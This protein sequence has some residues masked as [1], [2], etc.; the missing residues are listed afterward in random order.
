MAQ[1]ITLSENTLLKLLLRRGSNEERKLVKPSKGELIYTVDSRRVFV[2]DGST[3]GGYVVGNKFYGSGTDV[4]NPTIPQNT[5]LTNGYAYYGDSYFNTVN[6]SYYVL[7]GTDVTN[8]SSWQMVGNITTGNNTTTIRNNDGT[9]SL[10][11]LSAG[12]F[13][14]KIFTGGLSS[15]GKYIS[16]GPTI[17]TNTILPLNG[18]TLT[19]SAYGNHYIQISDS[20]LKFAPD[21]VIPLELPKYAKF[22]TAEVNFTQG[23]DW[24]NKTGYVY[25][26]QDTIEVRPTLGSTMTYLSQP[27]VIFGYVNYI[28]GQIDIDYNS[29]GGF[30]LS[31][32]NIDFTTSGPSTLTAYTTVSGISGTG[33]LQFD[34]FIQMEDTVP[35]YMSIAINTDANNGN[36]TPIS[37]NPFKL[38]QS[39]NYYTNFTFFAP[40]S[41]ATTSTNSVGTMKLTLSASSTS[42]PF[43]LNYLQ[44][45]AVL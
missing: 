20:V 30:G 26:N 44:V 40:M 5:S 23:T 11:P 35:A 28:P 45:T 21:A 37:L 19:L 14:S 18:T 25:K 29:M 34:G 42:G 15:N 24:N 2:G 10:L 4:I 16:L 12:S 3:Y 22:G 7:T 33:T 36:S 32:F 8:L 17:Y 38:I 41:A 9:I 39:G 13:D 43:R 6:A 27:A 31:T 1:P